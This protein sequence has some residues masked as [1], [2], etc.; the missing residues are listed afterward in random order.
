MSMVN[1]IHRINRLKIGLLKR[2]FEWFNKEKNMFEN[3]NLKWRKDW[4]KVELL[5]AEFNKSTFLL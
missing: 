3:I 5:P 4:P 2:N 1:H